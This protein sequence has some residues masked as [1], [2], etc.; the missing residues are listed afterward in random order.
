MSRHSKKRNVGLL[1]EFLVYKI[2]KSLVEGDQKN[3]NIA[4]KIIKRHFKPG[5]E[6]YK[7]FRIINSIRKTTVSSESIAVNILREAKS[8]VRARN[9]KELD[10]E[11]SLLI[12]DINYNLND[13]VFFDQQINEYKLLATI[14]TLINDWCDRNA[15]LKR[16]AEFEDSLLKHLTSEKKKQTEQIVE[17]SSPGE[18]RLLMKIMMNRLNETYNS[19]LSDDQKTLIKLYV[20]NNANTNVSQLCERL[21]LVKDELITNIDNY[22]KG[23]QSDQLTTNKLSEIKTLVSNENI[24]DINDQQMTRFLQYIKL[25]EELLTKDNVNV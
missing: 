10:R 21:I 17:N 15:D 7:E 9:S 22:I 16:I 14:Q 5:T 19:M 13:N 12:K 20:L 23:D 24:T 25:S 4:L 1:Y 18:T 8:A 2:S 11:K 6:L 3:A